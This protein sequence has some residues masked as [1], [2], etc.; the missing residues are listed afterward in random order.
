MK[1][2]LLALFLVLSFNVKAQSEIK[3]ECDIEHPAFNMLMMNF[4][5]KTPTKVEAYIGM[6]SG[7]ISGYWRFPE[8]TFKVKQLQYFRLLKTKVDMMDGLFNLRGVYFPHQ[9]F[10]VEPNHIYDVEFELENETL[11]GK[12]IAE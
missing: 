2:L 1:C 8:K 3:I 12:C 10:D 7:G 6:N 11:I 4:T 9:I 5:F